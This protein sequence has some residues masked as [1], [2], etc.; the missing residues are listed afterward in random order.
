MQH[1]RRGR[2]VPRSVRWREPRR[3]K[4]IR[5][6]TT[7]PQR[8]SGSVSA[9]AEHAGSPSERPR[10][11][12]SLPANR[13]ERD[14]PGASPKLAR[15]AR[16]PRLAHQGAAGPAHRSPFR[17]QGA[18]DREPRRACA[19]PRHRRRPEQGHTRRSRRYRRCRRYRRGGA[20]SHRRLR[21]R[22]R[23]VGAAAGRAAAGL[24]GRDRRRERSMGRVPSYGHPPLSKSTRLLKA[25]L[26]AREKERP[27][28]NA[29]SVPLWCLRPKGRRLFACPW[30]SR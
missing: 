7:A 23:P 6:R 27:R 26:S 21:G 13:V 25:A 18:A 30:P 2:R 15:T 24:H 3:H 20:V 11:S 14:P 1:A 28:R 8:G 29:A 9:R 17:A 22:L 19:R 4:T 10:A 5:A 16:E 12:V